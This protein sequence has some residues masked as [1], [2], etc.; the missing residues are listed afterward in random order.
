MDGT[1]VVTVPEGLMPGDEMN[2]SAGDQEFVVVVPP[3]CFAG[4][5]IEVALPPPEPQGSFMDVD[6][7]PD[8]RP[9]DELTV[10][11]DGTGPVTF[12]VPDDCQSPVR[13]ALP[14]KISIYGDLPANGVAGQPDQSLNLPPESPA[15]RDV[16]TGAHRVYQDPTSVEWV[17]SNGFF[18]GLGVEVLRTDGRRTF[19]TIEATDYL[20]GTYTVRMTNG[21][22]KYMVEEEDLRHYRAGKYHTGDLVIV[23]GEPR[24]RDGKMCEARIAGYDEYDARYSVRLND[25]Q[26][27]RD[28][29]LDCLKLHP[30]N[31]PRPDA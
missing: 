27:V 9:G 5:A 4:S 17:G 15:A 3:G 14:G 6:L 31:I 22:M 24:I 8:C 21:Q 29:Q 20:G 16:G 23:K 2:V 13:I 10:D 7:P 19:G 30:N 11:I 18:I 12:T 1:V 26:I 28:V 25:G